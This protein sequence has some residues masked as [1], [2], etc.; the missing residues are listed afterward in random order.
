MASL[1]NSIFG[2]DTPA[3]G[4][5]LFESKKFSVPSVLHK[6]FAAAKNSNTNHNSSGKDDV[7]EAP[8]TSEDFRSGVGSVDD[9]PSSSTTTLEDAPLASFTSPENAC[10]TKKTMEELKEEE[11]RTIFVGN[12]PPDISRRSLAGIFKS[13]GTV[14]S[15]R[16]RSIA[17]AGVKLPP[18]QAGNQVREEREFV[19]YDYL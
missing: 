7:M 6:T 11:E 12:L 10:T 2:G 15:T 13:C 1:I 19:R 16:L 17:V 8:T 9:K 4:S 18:E 3:V 14:A 5:D